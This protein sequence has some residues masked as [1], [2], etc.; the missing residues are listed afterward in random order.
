VSDQGEPDE[1]LLAH[2]HIIYHLIHLMIG[3]TP[4]QQAKS[5]SIYQDTIKRLVATTF[6]LLDTDTSVL[7]PVLLHL[8]LLF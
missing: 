5:F 7:V 1:V 6:H 4:L 3:K 8:I 2:L